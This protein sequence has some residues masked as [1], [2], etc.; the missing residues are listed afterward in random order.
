MVDDVNYPFCTD[1]REIELIKLLVTDLISD[2]YASRSKCHSLAVAEQV[3]DN[4]KHE[5]CL[6]LIGSSGGEACAF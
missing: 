4:T 5:T 6:V 3:V 1:S 2:P